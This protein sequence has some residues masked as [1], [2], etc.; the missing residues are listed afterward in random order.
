MQ[1]NQVYSKLWHG[2]NSLFKYFQEY[3]E[4][5]KDIDAY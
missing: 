4:I 5:F 2:Q 3:L 1:D